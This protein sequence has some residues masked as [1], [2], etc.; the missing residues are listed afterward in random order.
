MAHYIFRSITTYSFHCINEKSPI[1]L[2]LLCMIMLL[3]CLSRFDVY[4]GGPYHCAL[5]HFNFR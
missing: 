2:L 5:K 1:R 3:E 4:G